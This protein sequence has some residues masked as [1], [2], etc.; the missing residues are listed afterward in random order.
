MAASKRSGRYGA[1]MFMD[2]D[3]LKSVNDTHGHSVGD[4]LLIEVAQRISSC[5]RDTDTV[6]RFGGDEF[7]VVLGEL[8]AD[9]SESLKLSGIVAEKVRAVLD[10][11]FVLKIKKGDKPE[12]TL[13]HHCTSSIGVGLFLGHE[14]GPDEIIKRADTAMYQAKK[15]GGGNSIRFVDA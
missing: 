9:R 3:N 8:D 11:P 13:Q 12:A 10:K 1:L 15:E 5:V 4:A 14:F 6:A 7:V 2:L